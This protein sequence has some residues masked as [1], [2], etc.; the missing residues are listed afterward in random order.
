MA[1]DRA[2]GALKEMA[3]GDD[4]TDVQRSALFALAQIEGGGGVDVLIA[5]AK[6]HPNG[7]I[8]MEAIEMLGQSDDPKA[9]EALAE[10]VKK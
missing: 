3:Y 10:I 5:V 1:S 6:N 4:E 8:R 2:L 7:A 9:F